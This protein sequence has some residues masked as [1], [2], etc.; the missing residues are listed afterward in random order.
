MK[1]AEREQ[2]R[3]FVERWKRV[4]P[5]LA[6]IRQKELSEFDHAANWE[7][8]DALLDIGDRFGR[9]RKTSGMVEMQ[10]WFMKLA[11]QQGLRPRAVREKT[12]RYRTRRV[13]PSRHGRGKVK[14]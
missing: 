6:A 8:I 1:K 14:P 2:M 7:S 9:P 5:E 12:A 13:S 10:K 3:E 4:G 11:E